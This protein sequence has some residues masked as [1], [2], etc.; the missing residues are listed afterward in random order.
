M[1]NCQRT[2]FSFKD[3]CL[4]CLR[5]SLICLYLLAEIAVAQP[6]F[7]NHLGT[8]RTQTPLHGNPFIFGLDKK[9]SS[10]WKSSDIM[11]KLN[12][13]LG[14][15]KTPKSRLLIQAVATFETKSLVQNE[16]GHMGYKSSELD[17][18]SSPW[19]VQP[20]SSREDSTE[21]DDKEK[22]RRMRISKANKGNTPWNKGRKHSPGNNM[23]IQSGFC[24]INIYPLCI[25]Y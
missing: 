25:S 18:D 22:L 6:A 11:K 21:M 14:H 13:N 24:V 15:V 5:V 3:S 12:F 20:K 16:N 1:L 2:V 8:L 17:K 4:Y 23:L 19:T 9:L 10:S 7:Q